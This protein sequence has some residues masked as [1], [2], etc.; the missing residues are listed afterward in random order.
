MS[1]KV[2]VCAVAQIKN[3]PD[4]WYQRFQGMLFDC[5]ESIIKQTDVTFDL[6]KGIRNVITC[7]DDVFDARTISDNGMT[8]VVGAHFRG[9][10]KTAQDGINGLGYAM[11]SIL[12]GHDDVVLLIGHCKESQP[13]SRNMCTNLAFDPFFCRPLGLDFLNASAFQARAYMEKSGVTD[14]HLAKIV[15]R[16]RQLASKNPYARKNEPI[17][18]Q[19]VLDSPMLA[20]P[21][22]ELHQ[23]PVT[24]WAVGMLLCCE[25][26]AH[27]FTDSPVY[28]TG[29]GSCMDSYFLGD[30]DLTSNF[31]LK[32]AAQKAYQ[33][34]GISNPKDT[35]DLAEINDAYAYQLPMWAEG[36]GLADEGQGGKWIESKAMD[37]QNV[38]LSGGMLNGNPIMLGGLARATEAV[39]QLKGEAGDRQKQGAKKAVAHGTTGAAGQHHAVITLE[40]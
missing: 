11:A 19:D 21:I 40:N 30:K 7:S 38:N 10:E 33:M 36:L 4:I 29:F 1:N 37:S 28:L 12:S 14:A 34:A 20:D 18:E 24:D 17:S 22:R 35:F 15:A 16:S 6:E 31:A 3:E 23:Y 8:D 5:F 32:K 26:R 9:E 2:A 39:L 27:E 13:E 25:E